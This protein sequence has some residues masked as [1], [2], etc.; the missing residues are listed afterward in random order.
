MKTILFLALGLSASIALAQESRARGPRGG[1]APPEAMKECA[2]ELGLS[3]PEPGEGTIAAGSR[4]QISEEN[5][6]K[7]RQCLESKRPAGSE[8]GP[9]Q[10]DRQQIE[11]CLTAKGVTIPE[12]SQSGER[13]RLDE[14]TRTA[15]R[16]CIESTRSSST[17][18]ST[19]DSSRNA[20]LGGGVR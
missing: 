13:P 7:M 4:P 3:L 20:S 14:A 9:N 6:A 8:G 19:S 16:E 10:Q 1:G 5:R 2:A 12:P 15:L 17:S 18:T 11:A